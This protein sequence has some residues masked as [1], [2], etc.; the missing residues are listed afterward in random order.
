MKYFKR[1]WDETTGDELTDDWGKSVYYFET[2]NEMNVLRQIEKYENGKHLKYDS[3]YLEDKYGGLSE[4]QLELAEFS[5]FEI[6]KEEFN[7]VWDNSKYE[8]FPEIVRT[9]NVLC[10]Q[11]RLEGRRLSVGDI[12]SLIN[13]N[14]NLNIVL[15]DFELSHQQA[16]QAVLYCKLKKCEVDNPIKFCH[17]CTLQVKQDNSKIDEEKDNWII[18]ND[19]LSEY[20]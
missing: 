20:F 2:D 18:A 10:G 6:G 5:E 17:N 19:L 7:Q 4:V 8:R 15:Q 11:P 14:K 1:N 16:R 3:E 9:E 13:V 12:V